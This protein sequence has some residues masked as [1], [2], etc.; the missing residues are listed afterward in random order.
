MLPE[1][2]KNTEY[3]VLPETALTNTGWVKD[4]NRNLVF[5]YF[6]EHTDSFP[7]LKLI[8]G[9][10]SYEAI[11]NVEKIRN[12][13]NIPGIRYSKKYKTWYYTYN[14]ALHLEKN[15]PVKMRVKEGLVPFQEYAPYPKLIPRLTPVGID[16][17]FSTK[18]RNR[19]VFT[20]SNNTK[21]AAIICYE[22]VFSRIL[23]K[24][25]QQGAQAFFVILNEGWYSNLNV[26]KHFIQHSVIRAI[27]NRRSIAHSSNMGISAIINQKGE[28]I[29]QTNSKSADFLKNNI[30]LNRKVTL[31]ARG[32]NYIE[33]IA[34]FVFTSIFIYQL[35]QILK[36][37]LSK[38][39]EYKDKT[40]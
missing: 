33:I 11:P 17:Q 39:K 6:H 14:A 27:E 4:F 1:I 38:R 28:I 35:S 31:A 29:A 8:T 13:K 26:S 20:T 3:V 19:A 15:K 16:F 21:T 34:L 25:A 24:A 40:Y 2:T 10:I 37:Q 36:K 32:S 18:K 12:Y 23:S 30:L 9:A 22:V 7:D 5:N